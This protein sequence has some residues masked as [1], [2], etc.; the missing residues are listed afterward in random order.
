MYNL[1]LML[2]NDVIN[3]NILPRILYVIKQSNPTEII[4][5]VSLKMNGTGVINSCF[6]FQTTNMISLLK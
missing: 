6:Q 2:V 1:L 3:L 5:E 4:Y